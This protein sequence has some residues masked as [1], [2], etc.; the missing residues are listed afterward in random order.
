MENGEGFACGLAAARDMGAAVRSALVEMAQME[1]SQHL[2]RGKARALG[3]EGLTEADFRQIERSVRIT[4][5]SC[6]LI[7][8]SAPPRPALPN[9][10]NPVPALTG[11]MT[12]YAVDCTLPVLEIPVAALLAPALQPM[13]A[14]V[15]TER[16]RKTVSVCGGGLPFHHGVQ[17][18]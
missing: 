11:A 1:L 5:E 2:I 17:L 7:L 4:P 10:G 13:D 16:L 6:P 9:G 8:P 3:P 15:Q 14:A 18:V 12:L